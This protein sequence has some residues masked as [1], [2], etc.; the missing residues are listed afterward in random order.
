MNRPTARDKT[1]YALFT[2]KV[3]D[4]FDKFGSNA[5]SSI[6]GVN[7][8]VLQQAFI[9]NP[10]IKTANRRNRFAIKHT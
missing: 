9:L 1:G 7:D 4:L 6:G 8:N 5:P 10:F 3:S 2:L